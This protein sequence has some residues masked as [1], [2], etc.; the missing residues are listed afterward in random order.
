MHLSHCTLIA[1]G[2]SKKFI[3]QKSQSSSVFFSNKNSLHRSLHVIH[4]RH[5]LIKKLENAEPSILSCLQ[6]PNILKGP[7]FLPNSKEYIFPAN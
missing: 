7:G 4:S 1:T 3:A 2:I 6:M 5:F